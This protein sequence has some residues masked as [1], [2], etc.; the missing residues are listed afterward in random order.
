MGEW[1]KAGELWSTSGNSPWFCV[2]P[3]EEWDV[4]EEEVLKDFDEE[5]GDKRQ[6]LVY[7]SPARIN[8]FQ[9]FIGIE[10][11]KDA[12]I[13]KLE[14]CLL[15]EKEYA[16]GWEKWMDFEDKFETWEIQ[17]VN[18]D[19]EEGEGECPLYFEEDE[20]EEEDEEDEEE[21]E[22][23]PKKSERSTR[24]NTTKEDKASER[25]SAKGNS[26]QKSKKRHRGEEGEKPKKSSNHAD[27]KRKTK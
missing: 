19:E 23:I 15:T 18:S 16:L 3:M 21:K 22:E 14:E 10:M 1:E 11:D 7:R 20:E 24:S 13:R 17:L 12:I 26:K 27:K 8:A 5:L 6:E 4:D 2:I 9:V 25:K